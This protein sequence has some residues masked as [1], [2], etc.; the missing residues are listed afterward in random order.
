MTDK[1]WLTLMGLGAACMV[2][3][4][5]VVAT[6]PACAEVVVGNSPASDG[7]FAGGDGSAM[8]NCGAGSN[9]HFFP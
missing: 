3:L 8:P 9:D 5:I 7:A 1:Q 6:M 4:A 2:G